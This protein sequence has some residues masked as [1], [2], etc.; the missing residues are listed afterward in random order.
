MF[1][2]DLRGEGFSRAE[3]LVHMELE[4]AAQRAATRLCRKCHPVPV[5]SGRKGSGPQAAAAGL[6]L[7]KNPA[8][9]ELYV[10]S[11]NRYW[12]YTLFRYKARLCTSA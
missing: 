3:G 7:S 12:Q 4:M 8:A 1:P 5:S 11:R 2:G 9:N 10:C 6:R